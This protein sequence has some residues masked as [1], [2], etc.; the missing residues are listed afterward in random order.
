MSGVPAYGTSAAAARRSD[1]A[2]RD[3]KADLGR[4]QG[5]LAS[6]QAADSYAGLGAGAAASLSGRAALS[7]LQGYTANVADAQVRVGLMSRGVTRLAQ[8]ATSLAT[9]LSASPWSG[10]VGQTDTT[11]SAEDGLR[12]A[13]DLLNQDVGGRYL[14]SGRAADTRPVAGFS[15]IMDGGP[16][17][18]GLRQLVAER[19]EADLG[20]AGLGR[21]VLGGSGLAATVAEEAAG[22]PFGMKVAAASATGAAISATRVAGPP[23]SAAI[24][25]SGQPAAGDA[26]TVEL[27]LPDGSREPVTLTAGAPS[28]AGG[29]AIGATAADTAANLR[30]ALGA[31]I[32]SKATAALASAST[33]AAADGFFAG[34]A[35]SPPLRVAGPPFATATATVAGTAAD[36]VTWYRGDDGAGS[37]RETSPVRT[38]DGSTAAI[39]ARAN[40]A[41][42]RSVLASLG[43]LAADSFP[44]GDP[45]A[46]ARYAALATRVSA[47]SGSSPVAEIATDLGIAG[48]QL[49]AAKTGLAAGRVQLEDAI[50][51]VEQA[52]PTKVAM[53]LLATQ[54]RLQASYQTTSAIARLS[55]VDFI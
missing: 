9:S 19:K 36:T 49:G 1:L 6:G 39:G 10:P 44:S 52:D 48:G 29:F 45:T 25:L 23:A 16:G 51:G 35:S 30:A 43:A 47:A 8:I 7:T 11:V 15:E 13:I 21:L 37:A 50:A 17:R 41:G 3:L 38:G 46:G 54:T 33:R 34:S 18:A 55:L 40:E 31:A 32:A 14:F 53:A 27:A 26:V 22:L 2:F 4:L 24:A 12:Q 28:A 42:I 20:A 5:Q